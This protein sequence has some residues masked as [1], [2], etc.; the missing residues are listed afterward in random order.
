MIALLCKQKWIRIGIRIS[1][2][3]QDDSRKEIWRNATSRA[4]GHLGE[5]CWKGKDRAGDT[6]PEATSAVLAI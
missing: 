4:L 2:K 6:K 1:Y 3:S 5:G